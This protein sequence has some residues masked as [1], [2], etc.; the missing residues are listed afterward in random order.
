L[1]FNMTDTEARTRD[2]TGVTT[3]QIVREMLTEDTGRSLCD[4][5]GA[6]GRHWQRN[7]GRDFAAEPAVSWSW[8]A[9]KGRD[10]AGLLQPNA[11]TGLYQWMLHGLEFDADLQRRLDEFMALPENEDEGWLTLQELF[12]CRLRDEG[13]LEGNPEVFNTYNDVDNIDLSQNIQYVTLCMGG[14]SDPTHLIVSVHGGCDVRGGYTSPKCFQLTREYY[15]LL[16]SARAS[17]VYAGDYFWSWSDGCWRYVSDHNCNQVPDLF[18]L[19]AFDLTWL[20]D[21]ADDDE[22]A[23]Y[24]Q[25]ISTCDRQSEDLSD[26]K[27]D[28]LTKASYVEF[29]AGRKKAL[30]QELREHLVKVQMEQHDAVVLVDDGKAFLCLDDEVLELRVGNTFF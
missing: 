28:D 9:Y 21:E 22:S 24:L 14:Y 23:S 19:P 12:A 4:S 18:S 16:D 17:E 7:Q 10:G 1:E 30:Q 25:A 8:S 11:S 20:I 26:T 6:N 15:E 2:Y 5:G 29:L 13:E 3:E 27:L